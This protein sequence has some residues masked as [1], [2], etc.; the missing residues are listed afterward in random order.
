MCDLLASLN[1]VALFSTATVVILCVSYVQFQHKINVIFSSIIHCYLLWRHPIRSL[2]D[3]H[4]IPTCPYRWPDGQGDVG[5]FLEGEKN[6]KRWGEMYG[7]AYRLWCGMNQ[8]IVIQGAADVETVFKDSDKH[9]KAANNDAGWLMGELLGKCLG[10][11]S[12][13]AYRDLRLATTP[14]FTHKSSRAYLPRISSLVKQHLELLAADGPLRQ[15][16]INPVSD[17]A[18]LP[19]SIVAD[20]LYGASLTSGSRIEL[21][22]LK[23]LRES[24]W[25]RMIQG[26][27]TRYGISRYLPTKTRRDL[28]EFKRGWAD[29]NDKA[30]R[31]CL[32]EGDEEAVIVRLYAEVQRSGLDMEQLLQTVDE[33][34]FANLDVTMGGISWS[35]LFLAA[36]QD[37]QSELGSEIMHARREQELTWE[38]YIQSGST[39]LAASILESARLKPLAAFSVPQA[40][41]TDRIVAGFRIPSGTAF[42]VDTHALNINNPYWG[43]DGR[44]Y[45]PAR[46]LERRPAEMR[47]QFWRFGFGPRQC[48]GK[49]LVEFMIREL[50]AQLVEGHR[51]SLME[52]TSWDKNPTSWILHPN[53]EISCERRD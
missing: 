21:E 44:A 38:D 33:M 8:E 52:T 48:L 20:I 50:L 19:F 18:S 40:A 12:G 13:R 46:F 32:L 36:H 11:I 41:P 5:K 9:V 7:Q 27:A 14:P 53:T 4:P 28:K 22:R 16:R 34:L 26:G 37:I 42:V 15:N 23:E 1:A 25:A 6:S 45:R 49:F 29:F 10:L 30:Y 35:L 47:Y 3:G 39:L 31:A 17:L 43:P 51:L 2:R 24:L